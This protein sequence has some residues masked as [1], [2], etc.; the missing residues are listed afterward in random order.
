[1]NAKISRRGLMLVLSSPSG[2][3]KTTISRRLLDRDPGITLSVSVTT[4]PMRPGEQPG[5][6]YY[7]VD[8][9]EFDRMAGQGELLEHARVFGNCYGTPRHAV[10]TALSAGRDV[11]FDIDWQGMQQLAANARADLVSIF[12]LPPSGTELERRLH[13]RGQDSAEV[14]AQR[15]AKASDEIS[16]WGEYD[17]VIVNNDVDE[18]VTAVQA[19]LRAERLRRTRQVG[20]PA[21]VQSV[22]AAL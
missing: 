12:V 13:T 5:V 2:A 10:E 6:H 15:M 14:I 4:R 11:L 7:F 19:I 17:Y 16:H 8:M 20:L 1:M 21:F 22:Q 9:P 18:S 3:G